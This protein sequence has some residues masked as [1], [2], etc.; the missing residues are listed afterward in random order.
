MSSTSFSVLPSIGSDHYPILWHPSINMSTNHHRL[1]IKRTRWNL[2]E[3]FLTFTATYW[4]SLAV[5]MSHSATFFSLYERFLSLCISRLTFITF[6]KTIKPSLPE[7]I[8]DMIK[9]K[10]RY[11][12]LFRQTRHPFF[13]VVLR[14]MAIM[15]RKH[16]FLYKRKSWLN[17]CKSLN[18]CD[19]TSFWKKA[20]RHFNS[21]AAPIEGFLVNNNIVSSSTDMCNIARTFYEEQFA[22]HLITQSQIEI[23][24]NN[25]DVE[26]EKTLKSKP[27]IPIVITYHHLRRSIAS[28]KNK[29]STGMDGVSNRLIKLLPPNHLSII[30]S[31]LNNFAVTLQTPSHWHVAKMILLSKTKSKV[32][33]IE[34]TRPISLLPCFSKLFEKCF[35][36]HFRQWV[37]EQGI[38]PPE[39]SGFR[40]GHNMAVRLVAIV[41][42]IGQCLQKNT[43]A[44]ALFVDFRTA[45]NQLWFNGLWLK[46]VNLQC[47]LYLIS[48]LR[49]YLTGRK[50]YIDIKNTSSS[51]FN[52]SKGVPQGSCI[53]PVLFIIYHHDILE[54][55][56]T[57]HWKHLFADDLS[58]LFAPSSTMSSSNM[59]NSLTDQ[60]KHVLLR[61]INYSIKWKQPINFNKTYWTLFHR[62]VDPQIPDI[63]CE[64]YKIEHVKKFKYLGTIL[65]AKLSFTAHIDYIKTK[66]RT[67]LNIFKRLASSR[68][69]SEQVSYR[70]F[71]A[72]IR[73]YY[74][75]ILNIYPILTPTK[76]KQLE[77]LNRK[78]FRVIH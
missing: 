31:C 45:F 58:I 26:I 35:L 25:V 23:E 57:I 29:N 9:E 39:Q 22:S 51:M 41:D 62:Q 40:P 36:V 19:T 77:G 43:A 68:M 4:Q 20:K 32:T 70:L 1:P 7:Y 38:L 54:A 14:D 73:P 16:L 53:G 49:H 2:L 71:N 12:K 5:S 34:E 63:V 69:M 52:L 48:W 60:M 33:P 76:Q 18:D 61:L 10:R 30:L 6:R 21:R 28:L 42:Q 8:V 50:A 46:L 27:P 78:I 55:L 67:N 74:Q 3:I 75:S 56:S 13:A 11:L 65:D 24:A 37:N 72:F 17:Y 59:I 15:L 47:P 64:G 66:I 44:A